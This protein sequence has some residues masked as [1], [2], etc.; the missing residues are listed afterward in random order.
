MDFSWYLSRLGK[1]RPAEVF[2]RLVEYSSIYYTRIKYRNPSQWPYHRFA[3]EGVSLKLN[4]LPGCQMAD[5]RRH[6]Q[7]YNFT[8][9]LTK[10]VDWYF[11]D[12]KN[13]RWPDCHYSKINYRPGNHYGD[14]RVNW[15]LSRLQFLPVMAISDEDLAKGIILD[16][17]IK[18]P[19][20]HG[21]GYLASME[22]ALRWLSIYRAVCLFKNPLDLGFI[23]NLTG[24][25]VAS[26]NY[27]THHLSTH[28]SAGNHLIVE[29]V[30]LFWIGKALEEAPIGTKW[31][32]KARKILW[33][34][35][36]RQIHPDGSNK[37]QCFWYLG[38]VLDAVFH[39]FLLEDR[40]KIPEDVW[41]R[42][43]K[44]LEFVDEMILPNGSFPDYGDR[45]D[46]YVFRLHSKYGESPFPGLLN[47][48]AYF[49]KRPAW[50]RDYK[51]DKNRLAFWTGKDSLC[52]I[53]N[54]EGNDQKVFS[55][56]PHLKTYPDGG[57]TL[58]KWNKGKLFF[59][60]SLL[61]L[62]NTCGHGHADALSVLFS[63]GEIPVL[64][65]LGSGQY[66][67]DQDVRNFFRSTIAHNTVEVGRKNQTKILGPFMWENS[68]QTKLEKTQVSSSLS[69][70][71]SHNG[72]MDN[73]LISHTREVSWIAS[74]EIQIHD[75]F[76]GPG[77]LPIRGAFHLGPCQS[78]NQ[79]K[80]VINA[81]FGGFLLSLY[82]PSKFSLSIYFGSKFPFMGWR[83]TIYGKW[84]PIHSVIYSSRLQINDSYEIVL[85]VK[86][87]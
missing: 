71:A 58:M 76:T 82:F 59:R 7:I 48:G 21:P 26:G 3:P 43:E 47:I 55:E 51:E 69:A 36:C 24:L 70:V 52:A 77:G 56:E 72:Y 80:D 84:E 31:I 74:D 38:F 22:V 65:D 57:M 60:H 2:K 87:K 49:Y 20:L 39:Y 46:G 13:S 40:E 44:V 29:A 62:G 16:W 27:I 63:W 34:Q 8:F 61:G 37:E 1:M 75:K 41:E 15:E 50:Q 18:N 45:D 67:G 25:A 86:E 83:S 10:K 66:N 32:D 85:R 30:G 5:D 68:Y 35:I 11:S 53:K 12:K 78:I 81:D 23:K 4:I 6:Y 28:S 17:L 64:I 9:D 79:E 33:E 42:V 19:Y 54:G 14:I 73:F